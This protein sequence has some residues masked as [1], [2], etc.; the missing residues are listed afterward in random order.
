VQD[1]VADDD[2]AGEEGH[3]VRVIARPAGLA[4]RDEPP[5]VDREFDEIGRHPGQHGGAAGASRGQ[6]RRL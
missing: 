4:P 3:C 2:R 6:R 1:H 5:R